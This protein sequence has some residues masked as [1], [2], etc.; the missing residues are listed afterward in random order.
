MV[1]FSAVFSI[2]NFKHQSYGVRFWRQIIFV[3]IFL[4]LNKTHFSFWFLPLWDYLCLIL[5][6]SNPLNVLQ[7]WEKYDLMKKYRESVPQEDQDDAY[8]HFAQELR[9]IEAEQEAA[10]DKV[11][12]SSKETMS[13]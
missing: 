11:A 8:L 10:K 4:E 6:L 5:V 2:I 1:I 7:P 13:W 9:R 12:D 3:S